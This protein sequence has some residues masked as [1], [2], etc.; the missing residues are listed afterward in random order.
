M[1]RLNCWEFMK[2]GR[3]KNCPAYPS[4]GRECFAVTGTYCRGEK[5]PSYEGKIAKCRELCGFY[6][7]TMGLDIEEKV[8]IKSE[9]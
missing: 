3:E 4:H 8:T 5:Q 1:E 2:C 9:P 6:K 7:K